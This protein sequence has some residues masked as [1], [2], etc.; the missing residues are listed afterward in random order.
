MESLVN[1]R[2]LKYSL[3][4]LITLLGA[5]V[6]STDVN[7]TSTQE[8]AISPQVSSTVEFQVKCQ[9]V[10]LSP[11]PGPTEISIFPSFGSSD[12]SRG[13][14]DAYVT[15]IE[16][17][18]FQ[19]PGCAGLA[20]VLLKLE[21]KYSSNLLV[22]FRQFPLYDIHDKAMLAA[23]AS[24]A[25]SDLGKFW[26]MHDLLFLNYE[27]WKSKS[28]EEFISYIMEQSAILG[29]DKSVYKELLT[30]PSIIERVNDELEKSLKIGLRS[31]PFLLI[32]GQ[33]YNGPRDLNS[34]DSIIALII[35]GKRQFSSCPELNVDPQKQ[36][37]ATLHTEKGDVTIQLYP[38]KAPVAV[39]AFV[40]LARE[41]WYDNITFHR[42]IPGVVAQTGDPSATGL[43]GPGFLYQIETNNG[44]FFDRPGVVAM[45]NSG[46]D[47]NGSQFFITYKP[48]PELDGRF[49]IIGQVIDGLIALENLAPRDPDT[50]ENLPPGDRLLSISILEK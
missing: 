21:E 27:N 7:Q 5:C 15:I 9:I 39:N 38:D 18:D 14:A 28:T 31:T 23:Q 36:Y 42:V 11:T 19:C 12:H 46:S 4:L 22:I 48:L 3:I 33:I 41:G 37:I 25:A 2:N 8:K 10:Q 32:N 17:G 20:P 49:T 30:S 26:E 40:F 24:E 45:L 50:E 16:Y 47:T 35:L 1:W 13:P 43:G 44:L 34:L 29:L 6:K